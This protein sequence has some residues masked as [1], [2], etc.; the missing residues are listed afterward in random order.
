MPTKSAVFFRQCEY[1]ICSFDCRRNRPQYLRHRRQKIEQRRKHHHADGEM[2]CFVLC[3][4]CWQA[5]GKQ[6]E[7]QKPCEARQGA[8]ACVS[9]RVAAERTA[10]SLRDDGRMAV[11]AA[12]HP[13]GGAECGDF[14]APC[15]GIEQAAA[16]F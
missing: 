15:K 13:V 8:G 5:K 6:A 2:D 11:E 3:R 4:C 10:A 12:C 14:S 1:G 7:Q 9:M 16:V